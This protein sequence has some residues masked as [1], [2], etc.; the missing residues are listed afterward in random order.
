[1]PEGPEIRLAADEVA[2]AIV[3]RETTAVFFA[4]DHLKRYE[5]EL[6][7]VV[8][9]AVDTYGKGM[10]T[11]FGNG[12]CIYSHN[13]LY[14][15]WMVAKVGEM[16]D[17]K[18]PATSRSLRVAIH[19]EAASTLLYS[20]SEIQVL[21]EGEVD[22]HP[23]ISRIGPDLLHATT[24]V[25]L[26]RERLEGKKFNGRRYTSLLLDQGFLAGLGNYLRSEILFV[27]G[28]H[29]NKRPKDSTP[30][31]LDKLAKAA[32]GLTWQSYRTRGITND[33]V[34]AEKLKAEG[35]GYRDYRFWVFNRD[36]KPCYQC[37]TPIVKD[38]MGG[39]RI[40]FC[41]NCQPS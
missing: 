31:Q 20:A 12:L 33:L 24:T 18:P 16:P 35:H 32:S 21:H 37:G 40:Y 34:L 25:P 3:G 28:L 4:F 8:V 15:L 22:A 2:E 36:G 27:S 23:F 13:Q 9:T 11:R 29:P 41:P 38:V 6:T 39:R 19:N 7:G 30:E 10:V 14:G 26:I 5:A 17:G 1:M